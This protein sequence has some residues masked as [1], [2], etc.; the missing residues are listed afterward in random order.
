MHFQGG[1]SLLSQNVYRNTNLLVVAYLRDRM[2]A[3]CMHLHPRW[4]DSRNSHFADSEYSDA[5]DSPAETSINE[6]AP[7]NST[8]DHIYIDW[9][10]VYART[11]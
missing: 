2:D 4:Q 8:I 10:A 7:A 3:H 11:T 6:A 9:I 1:T 5:L